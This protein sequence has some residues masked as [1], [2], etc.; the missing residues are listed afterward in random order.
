MLSGSGLRAISSSTPECAK[1]MPSAARLA[2]AAGGRNSGWVRLR[3]GLV[4]SIIAAGSLLGLAA[5]GGSSSN[6]TAG[7]TPAAG[8]P[9]VT[10]TSSAPAASASASAGGFCGSITSSL[11]GLK[12]LSG[13]AY[14]AKPADLKALIAQARANA[15]RIESTAPAAIR[16][17]VRTLYGA[18]LSYYD[19]I[20]A[21]GYDIRKVDFSKLTA[22]S[23][24]NVLQATERISAYVQSECGVTLGPSA[25]P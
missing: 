13:K 1:P 9:A 10:A 6:S 16:G 4:A 22:L 11:N 15:D 2:A 12:D 18:V 20:A 17:D 21:A 25:V 7:A 3:S 23:S 24:S 5:C 8:G 14:T 19:A